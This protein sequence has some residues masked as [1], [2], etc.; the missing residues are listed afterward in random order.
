MKNV[1]VPPAVNDV[2]G[3]HTAQSFLYYWLKGR[4][5]VVVS[6][7]ILA[8]AIIWFG[9]ESNREDVFP[10][11]MICAALIPPL[12]QKRIQH[13]GKQVRIELTSSGVRIVDS[14]IELPFVDPMKDSQY[15]VAR[16]KLKGDYI[17]VQTVGTTVRKVFLNGKE[18]DEVKFSIPSAMKG[19][20]EEWVKSLNDL[21]AKA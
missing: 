11:L 7:L 14:D 4:V 6:V 3:I 12:F 9:G 15:G 1:F 10:I 19:H 20:A 5:Y 13:L 8:P 21:A 2:I 17:M 16:F 18:I